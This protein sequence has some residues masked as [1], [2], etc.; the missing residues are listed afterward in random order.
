[1]GGF[2]KS[3]NIL[4]HLRAIIA[5]SS[6]HVS[7]IH[8]TVSRL[9]S[10]SANLSIFSLYLTFATAL[11]LFLAGFQHITGRDAQQSDAQKSLSLCFHLNSSSWVIL[12][13]ICALMALVIN[14]LLQANIYNRVTMQTSSLW[15]II[16]L[17]GESHQTRQEHVQVVCHFKIK[18]KK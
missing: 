15:I 6:S 3:L 18:R 7:T 11:L 4:K 13:S 14:A 16:T 1:M 2:N 9:H 8:K 17:L 10:G 5:F 12:I